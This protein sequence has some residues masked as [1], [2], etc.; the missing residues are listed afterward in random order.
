MEADPGSGALASGN[1]AELVKEGSPWF[2][3]MIVTVAQI[4]TL[5]CLKFCWVLSAEVV[6]LSCKNFSEDIC[7]F[8]FS[9]YFSL[10]KVVLFNNSLFWSIIH[11]TR[12]F[13]IFVIIIEETSSIKNKSH[14]CF[15]ELINRQMWAFTH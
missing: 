12:G 11:S 4:K 7:K 6:Y 14:V 3:G 1:V 15:C 10:Q 13:T 2:L 5:M 9:C 8:L